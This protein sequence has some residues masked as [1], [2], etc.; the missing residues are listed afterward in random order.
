MVPSVTE[1]TLTGDVV[2]GRPQV[3]PTV[4]SKQEVYGVGPGVLFHWVG[5][6]F[7]AVCEE[8]LLE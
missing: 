5:G 4:C 8:D 2:R 7:G 1:V 3:G 6:C